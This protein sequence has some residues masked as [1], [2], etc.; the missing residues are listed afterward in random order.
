MDEIQ[1]MTTV[2]SRLKAIEKMIEDG[3][4]SARTD[5][6]ITK[7]SSTDADNSNSRNNVISARTKS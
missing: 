1:D 2:T 6:N 5:S 3:S 4:I 7:D